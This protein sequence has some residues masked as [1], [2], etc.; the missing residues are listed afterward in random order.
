[1]RFLRVTAGLLALVVVV[2]VAVLVWY[3][4]ASAPPHAGR[5]EVS[6]IDATLRIERDVNGVPHI[7]ALSERDAAFGLGYAHAQ[8]RLWQM[9]M[10]R[11]I[12]AGRLAE[13]VGAAALE[14]DR[15]LRTIGIA[16]TAEGIYR[17]LD[18]EHRA[19]LDAY[20]AGVNAHLATRRGPLPPEFIL[21]R[22]SAPEP[23]SP[24]DSIG[25]SLM[26]AWDLARYAMTMELRR[27]ELAQRFSVA[28][29]DDIYPPYPGE[30]APPVADFAQFYRMLGVRS[31]EAGGA[32]FAQVPG[33]GLGVGDAVGSNAWV[34]S[35][36]RATSGKPLLAN[37]P[38][39]GLSAPSVW[40]FAALSAPGVDVIGAT[41]PGVP[42]V[43]LG[44]NDRIAWSFTNA[45]ADQLDLY[46]ER[47]NPADP[48]EYETPAGWVPFSVTRERI[49]VK[50]GSDVE[51]VVRSTRHGPVMSGLPAFDRVL[52]PDR[53]VLALNWS[54]LAHDDRTMIAIRALNK[55]R[56][57]D[58]A[59]RALALFDL[60]TQAALLADVDGDIGLIVTGRVPLRR[61]DN[62]LRGIA[63]APGWD[64]RY[65]WDGYL[66][67]AAKP[68]L[69]N[70]VEGFIA[71]ANQKLGEARYPYHLT[72]DWFLPFRADRIAQRI[73]E[74]TRHDVASLQAVQADIVSPAAL[75]LLALL[76]E[77]QPATVAGREALTRLAAWDGAMR[78]D[79]AEPL[80]FHAWMREL[81]HRV[82]ADDFGPLTA[83]YIDAA[84]V[85]A[86]L[87]HVLSGRAN[88]RDWCDDRTTPH[89]FE[90][91]GALAADALDA[92]ATQLTQ[93]SGLDVGALRWGSVH[94]AVAQHRPLSS[95]PF[96]ARLFEQRIA[97]PGDTY[98]I[99][100][101]ALTHDASAPFATR[102]AASLRA[103]YDLAALADGSVWIQS[104][105][106]SGSPLSRQ[107]ASMQLPWRNVDYL[108]MRPAPPNEAKVLE[109][110]PAAR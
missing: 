78:I 96:L 45:G 47:L 106:Q 8:D 99:N 69:R 19:L 15:F 59:E 107:Y 29:I 105:G 81:K 18:D 43:V 48:G 95:V 58:E 54:A 6:G 7:V 49:V 110:V 13:I 10:N 100:A 17:Q 98:T 38:H 46:L 60:V 30:T 108:P 74:R 50:G 56:N 101:G 26:M 62:D 90:T 104:T 3:R 51:L 84:E 68:R 87:R 72:Y 85:T 34:V 63:P 53:Y 97:Y 44:R 42:G 32:Q 12:A 93:A 55:A 39:L 92:A 4:Q 5:V 76:R 20:S 82:F 22:A 23:W 16:R 57:V 36:A 65:D 28:E 103:V 1:V 14:T 109:L 24:A 25:W 33:A 11:R 2:A 102:H 80:L 27:L 83:G 88:A 40:Y 21:T 86:A 35:G 66:P 37:D 73:G 89:R 31:S 52:A 79:A 94:V 71:S 9:E 77:T 67:Q 70:P 64:S 91:C 75:E 61:H 41:L